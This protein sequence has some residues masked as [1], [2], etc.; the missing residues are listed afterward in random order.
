MK[1]ITILPGLLLLFAFSPITTNAQFWKKI[2]DKVEKKAVDVTDDMLNGST[3]EEESTAQGNA[4][5]GQVPYVEEVFSFVPGSNIYFQDNYDNE[6]L[7]SMPRYWKTNGTGSIVEI[8][9]LPGKWLKLGDR[10]SFKL[11]TLLAMPKGK[12][13]L[14][15]DI[16]TRSD[17]AKDI[18]GMNF[19]FSKDNAVRSWISDAYNDNSI[20]STELHFWNRA[21][22]NSSSDTK[23]SNTL[24]FPLDNYGNALIH[25]SIAVDGD[26][27][28][29]YLDK[30]KL[31][32]AKMFLNKPTK[33]FYVSAPLDMDQG[34]QLFIGNLKIANN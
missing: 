22:S 29:L 20:T 9:G 31:L 25:V 16:V 21:V 10:S 33:Y 30:S 7:G 8:P 14:E 32:D 19:G 12:F 26:Q 3:D 5:K 17:K 27:M 15:F 2:Q 6:N 34:A 28:R 24:D 4:S 13:T 18:G 1:K 11:D 23:V